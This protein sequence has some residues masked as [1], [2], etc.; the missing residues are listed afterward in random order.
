MGRR[1]LVGPATK[2][3][4]TRFQ[5]ANDARDE[6]YTLRGLAEAAEVTKGVVEN[7][8][9]G[10]TSI[11]IESYIR[12]CRALAIDPSDLMTQAQR[13]DLAYPPTGVTVDIAAIGLLDQDPV[14]ADAERIESLP[15]P[16]P[17]PRPSPSS[18]QSNR[19]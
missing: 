19:P 15:D 1:A 3:V 18:A 8:L 13:A 16:R 6:P 4:A 5:Q 2:L 12:L 17:N 9:S 7:A 10:S 14:L 11:A